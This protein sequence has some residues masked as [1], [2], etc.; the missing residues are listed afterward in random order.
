[1]LRLVDGYQPESETFDALAKAGLPK[2]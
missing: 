1:L 2:A